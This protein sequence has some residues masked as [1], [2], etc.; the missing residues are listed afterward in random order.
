MARS[1]SRNYGDQLVPLMVE[2]LWKTGRNWR[3]Y[4]AWRMYAVVEYL[5]RHGDASILDPSI[6]VLVS[7]P[8]RQQELPDRGSEYPP[9]EPDIRAGAEL[10]DQMA[11]YEPLLLL[12]AFGG[13]SALPALRRHTDRPETPVGSKG[14]L[15]TTIKLL[16]RQLEAKKQGL[17]VE[18]IGVFDLCAELGDR[19]TLENMRAVWGEGRGFYGERARQAMANLEK[20]LEQEKQSEGVK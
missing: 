1:A 4:K 20:R 14:V 9:M 16:T 18:E 19:T 8:S 15:A 11:P 6:D 10:A 5:K 13:E 7:Q 12:V 2:C 3:G 17:P